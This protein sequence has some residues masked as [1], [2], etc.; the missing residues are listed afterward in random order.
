MKRV[1]IAAFAML[2][3]AAG[4]VAAEKPAAA[5]DKAATSN[6]PNFSGEW[7]MNAAKSNFGQLPAPAKF[8]RKIQHSEPSL[9][10]IEEQSA[11][12]S[13]STTTRRIT[14]DGKSVTLELNGAPALCSS[15]WDGADLV[16]T[17]ALDT[18]GLKFTDRMSLSSDGKVLTSKVQIVSPQGDAELIIVFDRQ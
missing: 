13:D 5:A 17:T 1:L 10:V 18:V 11:G 16:A 3:I 6:K 9:T 2:T 8:V 14:T 7:T 12:G 4:A 15:V